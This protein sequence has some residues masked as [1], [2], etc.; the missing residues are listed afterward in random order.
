MMVIDTPFMHSA[1]SPINVC[2]LLNAVLLGFIYVYINGVGCYGWQVHC[3]I[4]WWPL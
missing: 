2:L 4:C 3:N 1:G